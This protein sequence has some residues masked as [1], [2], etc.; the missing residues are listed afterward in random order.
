MKHLHFYVILAAML[1]LCN[2]GWSQSFEVEDRGL[3]EFFRNIPIDY[4]V[5]ARRGA[6][7]VAKSGSSRDL[8]PDHVNNQATD[9][10]PPIFNQS[11][12]SCGSS[13]N[14]AYML[15]YEL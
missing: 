2:G 11:G 14:V 5:G 4:S 8:R 1:L 13:A 7:G 6:D 12:G 9:F 10:F 3:Y 15:C